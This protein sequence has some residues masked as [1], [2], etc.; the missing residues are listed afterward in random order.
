MGE[1]R[2]E[3]EERRKRKE[4]LDEVCMS[5]G[6]T[7]GKGHWDRAS[8]YLFRID[9]YVN[10]RRKGGSFACGIRKGNKVFFRHAE[11]FATFVMTSCYLFFLE[12]YSW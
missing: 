1:K 8:F 2:R 5:E 7:Y 12:K 3:K 6:R 11:D 9:L 10:K 4:L